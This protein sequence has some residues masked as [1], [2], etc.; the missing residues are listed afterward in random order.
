MYLFLIKVVTRPSI[1]YLTS[2][3]SMSRHWL[4]DNRRLPPQSIM[5]A[6]TGTF[7]TKMFSP[8][9]TIHKKKETPREFFKNFSILFKE[10]EN[11]NLLKL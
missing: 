8:V 4:N 7:K 5:L 1:A 3:G 11:H 6:F 10:N 2:S 9:F